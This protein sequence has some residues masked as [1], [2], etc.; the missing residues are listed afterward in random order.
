MRFSTL[1]DG[2]PRL[3]LLVAGCLLTASTAFGQN[4]YQVAGE[5]ILDKLNTKFY[6][7]SKQLYVEQIDGNENVIVERLAHVTGAAL[8]CSRQPG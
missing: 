3:A 4:K 1:I 6:N 7:A 2:G 8:W 5:A